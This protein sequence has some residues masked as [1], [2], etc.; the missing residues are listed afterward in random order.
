MSND[1]IYSQQQKF[2][3]NPPQ[4]LELIQMAPETELECGV[5]SSSLEHIQLD[6]RYGL[7]MGLDALPQLRVLADK[8]IA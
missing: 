7:E 5:I 6:Y 3:S 8:V 4:D 2:I 1:K